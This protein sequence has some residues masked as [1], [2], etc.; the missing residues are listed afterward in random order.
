MLVL[1]DSLRTPVVIL[2]CLAQ[3]DIIHVADISA[4]PASRAFPD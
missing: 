4:R 3:L 2:E 1:N